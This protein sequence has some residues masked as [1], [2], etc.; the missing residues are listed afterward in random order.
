[1]GI[2]ISEE[3]ILKELIRLLERRENIK[4]LTEYFYST[5]D[6]YNIAVMY[7]DLTGEDLGIR[8]KT[9]NKLANYMKKY[10]GNVNTNLYYYFLNQDKHTELAENVIKV[11]DESD[12]IFYNRRNV[13]KL[14]EKEFLEIERDFLASYDER[15]LKLFNS[16][17][18]RGLIDMRGNTNA[19]VYLTLSSNNHY[20]V[21]PDEYNITNLSAV[22]HELGHLFGY[23]VLDVRSKKQLNNSNITYYE[24]ISHYMELCLFEYLKK[25]HVYLGD[26]LIEENDY[27]SRIKEYFDS[28]YICKDID[29]K[30]CDDEDLLDISDSYVYSYGI[31]IG[32]LLHERYLENPI[33]TKKDID[34][35]LFYQG[36]LD[37]D[38]ELEVIGLSYEDLNN[39]KVLSKRLQK[40]T[41]N[42][43]KYN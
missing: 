14:T 28:L 33:E 25:N 9:N 2:R 3:T 19:G 42:Y 38:Q 23:T 43:R 7:Y 6:I 5:S 39:T 22:S 11:F 41:E 36:L 8:A 35:Y 40:H 12:F 27:Y 4:S 31:L 34:N 37:K 24:S 1:M 21:L 10:M 32:T 26:T 29:T 20:V 18:E 13:N 15:I 16:H 30:E 17:L